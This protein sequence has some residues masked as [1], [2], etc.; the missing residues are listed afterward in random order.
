MSS[1]ERKTSKE[2]LATLE[3]AGLSGPGADELLQVT[4]HAVTEAGQ[5]LLQTY[6]RGVRQLDLQTLLANIKAKE[7]ISGPIL[8]RS[9]ADAL[10]NTNWDADEFEGGDLPQGLWWGY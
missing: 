9:L 6:S 1:T 5:A 4:I 2:T 10:P 7:E 8:K 3:E